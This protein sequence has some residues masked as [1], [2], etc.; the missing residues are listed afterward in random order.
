MKLELE[1]R[2]EDNK[3]VL[4]KLIILDKHAESAIWNKLKSNVFLESYSLNKDKFKDFETIE[5]KN[6]Y[7]LVSKKLSE[8][9]NQ[10]N[11]KIIL[12]WFSENETLITDMDTFKNNWDSFFQ[13][14]SDDR[15]IIRE[16]WDWIIYLSHFECL[17][18]GSKIK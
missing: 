16:D 13:P 17:Q 15:L 18:Y 3:E 4:E 1:W 5:F 10:I 8:L 6:N 11:Q 7:E 12:T 2:F 9:S 14:S